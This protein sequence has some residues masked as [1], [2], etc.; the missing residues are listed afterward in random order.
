M[1]QLINKTDGKFTRDDE[2]TMTHACEIVASSLQNM[3]LRERRGASQARA[4]SPQPSS[5]PQNA[6]SSYYDDDASILEDDF[7][8][9]DEGDGLALG[10]EDDPV[11]RS[12]QPT[13]RSFAA[14]GQ[15]VPDDVSESEDQSIDPSFNAGRNRGPA[16]EADDPSDEY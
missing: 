1:A 8:S 14:N 11:L 9:G 15:G 3:L 13:S 10:D 12:Q 7:L 5:S 2:I 4:E 6:P 16:S